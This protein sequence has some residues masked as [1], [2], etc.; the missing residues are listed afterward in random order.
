MSIK[1]LAAVAAALVT[2][3]LSGNWFGG[4]VVGDRFTEPVRENRPP[5]RPNPVDSRNWFG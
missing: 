3:V 2:R 4:C 5:K 1:A